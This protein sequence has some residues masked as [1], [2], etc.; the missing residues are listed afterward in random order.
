MYIFYRDVVFI[1]ILLV[2]KE[3]LKKEKINKYDSQ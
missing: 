1:P 3:S 2:I